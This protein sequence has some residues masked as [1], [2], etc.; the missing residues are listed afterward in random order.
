M[1]ADSAEGKLTES[2]HRTALGTAPPSSSFA[3][4]RFA[5]DLEQ[6]IRE[7][8]MHPPSY[9][10]SS[11]PF[12][13]AELAGGGGGIAT[14]NGASSN[15]NV[16][17]AACHAGRQGRQ[18]SRR[19]PPAN[20]HRATSGL[21]DAGT[22]D[23]DASPEQLGQSH[24]GPIATQRE[25]AG[26]SRD[27]PGTR[28]N[29]GH[30][31]RCEASL[32]I[33]TNTFDR[34]KKKNHQCN[35]RSGVLSL[36][37]GQLTARYEFVQ[38]I[39][40]GEWGSIWTAFPIKE[41]DHLPSFAY[42][43]I[44]ARK[45]NGQGLVKIDNPNHRLL[46][47]KVCTRER[48]SQ[49]SARTERLWH[50]FK[51][52][53][54]L[55]DSSGST[56]GDAAT[57][58]S[59]AP[60][61]GTKADRPFGCDWHASIVKFYEFII[62]PS[63]AMIVMPCYDE[64]MKVGLPEERCRSYFQQLLSGMLW[65]HQ[66]NICH[67][68]IKVANILVN[69]DQGLLGKGIP[70][71]VDFGFATIHDPTK[72]DAFH[73]RVSWGTPEYLAP[74]RA[75]GDLHDE[76][77]SDV[78]SLGVTFFE[79]AVTRTP[80]EQQDEEF[81]TR[82]QLQMYYLRTISGVWVG[83]WD[84]PAEL[85]DLVR[86]MLTP[87]PADRID[88][89][90]A[91]LHP[92]FD[93]NN[94]T[95]DNSLEDIL[96]MFPTDD[97]DGDSA[98]DG[99]L[100]DRSGE[101]AA[102]SLKTGSRANANSPRLGRH[103]P[104]A[105]TKRLQDGLCDADLA[106]SSVC[107]E[108]EEIPQLLA[109]H[110]AE[111]LDPR[112]TTPPSPTL[113][114]VGID[115]HLTDLAQA[116][117]PW[118]LQRAVR[119]SRVQPKRPVDPDFGS[120]RVLNG[121]GRDCATPNMAI[122]S[123]TPPLQ[124]PLRPATA[125]CAMGG[126]WQSPSPLKLDETSVA[127]S[128]LASQTP[129]KKALLNAAARM[130]LL[131][132]DPVVASKSPSPSKRAYRQPYSILPKMPSM[133]FG[134]AASEALRRSHPHAESDDIFS[135]DMLS[136]TAAQ[137]GSPAPRR[138]Q[139][140]LPP[141]AA[142]VPA[143]ITSPSPAHSTSKPGNRVVASLA[144]KFDSPARIEPNLRDSP[145]H[146]P[147]IRHHEASKGKHG[148]RR[149]HSCSKAVQTEQ[150][151]F[152]RLS[153]G[154]QANTIELCDDNSK[155]SLQ[156]DQVGQADPVVAGAA[157]ISAL[158]DATGPCEAQSPIT[159]VPTSTQDS[160]S[161]C[162]YVSSQASPR[163]RAAREAAATD[164]IAG[165]ARPERSQSISN[166]FGFASRP[167]TASA[168]PKLAAMPC[169]E[170]KP[171]NHSRKRQ[172]LHRRTRTETDS[173]D[174]RRRLDHMGAIAEALAQMISE[175]RTSLLDRE[176]VGA[177]NDEIEV[178]VYKE[179]PSTP[180]HLVETMQQLEAQVLG[181]SSPPQDCERTNSPGWVTRHFS[182]E[183]GSLS[184]K[185]QGSDGRAETE[186]SRGGPRCP[187][188][189]QLRTRGE[190]AATV[191]PARITSRQ[192][193]IVDT[194]DSR[195]ETLASL[196]AAIDACGDGLPLDSPPIL[197]KHSFET[198]QPGRGD[199]HE[200]VHA[201]R[202]VSAKLSPTLLQNHD[203]EQMSRPSVDGARKTVPRDLTGR[204]HRSEARK[205]QQQQQQHQHFNGAASS[206]ESIEELALDSPPLDRSLSSRSVLF[207]RAT[208]RRTR[209]LAGL[210]F[211]RSPGF[212]PSVKEDGSSTTQT[213]NAPGSECIAH[214]VEVMAS[215]AS[216][217][218]RAAKAAPGR[219][220]MATPP[221]EAE[222]VAAP[223]SA[224]LTPIAEADKNDSGR[225][226]I[227]PEGTV[228]QASARRPSIVAS[229]RSLARRTNRTALG[230]SPLDAPLSFCSALDFSV[231]ATQTLPARRSSLN[232]ATS[233]GHR[234]SQKLPAKA[235]RKV[236]VQREPTRSARG[237]GG[238]GSLWRL[239]RGGGAGDAPGESTVVAKRPQ[240][241]REVSDLSIATIA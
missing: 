186:E 100:D 216:Y 53:R 214:A 56:D 90:D 98:P 91:L 219:L 141:A 35:E 76:R 195:P 154:I 114:A 64:P 230:G 174:V 131:R 5:I 10:A 13:S 203:Q 67:N 39:G 43:H 124:T 106:G 21:A 189:R 82:E 97:E 136:K 96:D 65:L 115:S 7:L 192:E 16:A 225:Y 196:R 169:S 178:A 144:K 25:N 87:T 38:E 19:Q 108:V 150:K 151:L 18:V 133:Q 107:R 84:I 117:P 30:Q 179:R 204:A 177:S 166:S 99:N 81:V 61:R 209:S 80:F 42:P 51:V 2:T 48:N 23:R 138:G 63:I 74:E 190:S 229:P 31:G 167:A 213:P 41:L 199:S 20:D 60:H 57:E 12:R 73:T 69:Y 240:Q 44:T 62:T 101:G 121:Q 120:L 149:S 172:N 236:K 158:A 113:S 26:K 123:R 220:Q 27:A 147:P 95:F 142:K 17:P 125:S 205:R 86:R 208:L 148:H 122:A 171:S 75:R 164:A 116:T 105:F 187:S 134:R 215:P 146:T 193:R 52:L 160:I 33:E 8:D 109:P 197:A 1:S 188:H 223:A 224:R 226:S 234:H 237:G 198:Y 227:E 139:G 201:Q 217:P 161:V 181:P 168:V 54:S 143:V 153:V 70:I 152:Q 92:Y 15:R 185:P 241:R 118:A 110:L 175:T 11:A 235:A 184:D 129:R 155:A 77:A 176:A 104:L 212:S 22:T 36:S 218:R 88:S 157:S 103:T 83:S 9:G 34:K 231:A 191:T 137:R 211:P 140:A 127:N 162:S 29:P 221:S 68:D 182:M 71:L 112:P 4:T 165:L 93:P 228:A 3:N 233:S 46:A 59:S 210:F 163:D 159:S 239:F 183:F 45:L 89:A 40:S 173:I 180:A 145:K 47:I 78:W 58:A 232:R 128:P 206:S 135:Q 156:A 194:V 222:P 28:Q 49:S 130:G 72:K 126:T 32:R 200:R 14:T 170:T 55:V 37:D 50:E 202:G 119:R 79:M 132:A 85:E 207:A 6:E 111:R 24:R 238:F 94:N 66:R 102:A